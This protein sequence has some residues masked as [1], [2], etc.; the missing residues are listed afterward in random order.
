MM[1]R[2][3]FDSQVF[4]HHA[5]STLP[6]LRNHGRH[7]LVRPD[8]S[9]LTVL[10]W[11]GAAPCLRV[12]EGRTLAAEHA[13]PAEPDAACLL[14]AGSGNL[15]VWFSCGGEIFRADSPQAAP[16]P[17]GARGTLQDIVLLPDGRVAAAVKRD[18][19][20]FLLT[21]DGTRF[22]EAHMDDG[23]GRACLELDADGHLHIAYE[24]RQG[25]EYRCVAP[26]FDI[27]SLQ[28]T[29]AERAAQAYGAHPVLLA[30]GRFLLLAYHGEFARRPS[31][32]HWGDAWER[33]GR[34]GY[35]GVLVRETNSDWRRYRV[36]DSRQ[37]VKPWR[38]IDT[39]FGGG[40]EVEMRVRVEMFCPPALTAGPD[41]VPQVLWADTERRWIYAARFLEDGFAPAIE[42]RGPLEQL[43]WCLTPRRV[44]PNTQGLPL[45]MMT[46]TRGHLDS[47]ALP[48][49]TVDTIGRRIDF[50]QCDELARLQG[51]EPAVEQLRRH[52]ENPIMPRGEPGSRDDGGIVACVARD[53]DGWQA[54]TMYMSAI[55]GADIPTLEKWKTWG[56]MDG[57]ATSRDGIHWTK[58][59]PLPLAERYSVDGGTYHQYSIRY[60][61]DDNEPNADWRFKGLWRAQDAGPWGWVAV[62]SPDAKIWTSVR[63]DNAVFNADD[64]ICIWRDEADIPARRFKASSISRSFCG[65]V[66]CQWT[67][68]NGVYWNDERDTLDFADPFGA[69][70]DVGTTGRI[71][72][73][74]WSGPDDEDEL[75][76]GYV[77]RDGDR[78][79]LH[80]MKWTQ[81]GHVYVALATSRDAINFSRVRG[82]AVT[83]PLGEAGTWDAGRLQIWGAP[84]L[85]E[86]VWRQYYTGCGWK[87]GLAG[88][89]ARTSMAGMNAPFQMGLAEIEV[90]RWAHLRLAP[91]ADTGELRT[92]RL[93]LA[94]R[95]GLQLDVAG[96]TRRGSEIGCAIFDATTAQP[97]PGYGYD[98]CDPLPGDDRALRVT[99]RGQGLEELRDAHIAIGV[100]L[101]GHG[102]R[103]YGIDLKPHKER[104]DA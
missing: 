95:H 32:K 96:M 104:R 30:H 92:V 74:S 91:E 1:P 5:E 94:G 37:I 38:P 81:D 42:A 26:E 8:G 102:A 13:L 49:A 67:S 66:C 97:L 60:L 87:H 86:G 31:Y 75:H 25:I 7:L 24:K 83:L 72:L 35:I 58:L 53:G 16:A 55:E 12:W 54:E 65:R 43:H 17:W 6:L 70:P 10:T 19:D 99:W 45:A 71:L 64:D 85:V 82:G 90:G 59:D 28:F 21:G 93:R 44:P 15:Q 89:G 27:R 100:R 23:A 22:D 47:I 56:R 68:A 18:A 14:D 2:T 39:A 62:V 40:P 4:Y 98:D 76:G 73:D 63:A 29:R 46:K 20:L 41:G 9:I 77:F 48:P 61:R 80:Y 84:I 50:L 88:L 79:L 103:L 34:G 69:K 33:L 101:A 57:R 52:P 3:Q 51:L 78:W 11:G 36:A